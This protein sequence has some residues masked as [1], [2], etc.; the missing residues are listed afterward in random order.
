MKKGKCPLCR[1]HYK[2]TNPKNIHHLWPREFYH[3]AGLTAEICR[4]CH[5]EFEKANPH[6]V[7][8][9]TQE[10]EKLWYDFV[11]KKREQSSISLSDE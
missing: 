1:Q 9:T 7:V 5:N 6:T 10:C 8:L 11:L 2:P 3:G 4:A